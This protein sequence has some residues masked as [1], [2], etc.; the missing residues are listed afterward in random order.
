MLLQIITLLKEILA[1]LIQ[2]RAELPGL[3][4]QQ[5]PLEEELLDNSDAKRLLKICAKT[6]YRWRKKK[7]ISSRLIG[8]KLYYVKAELIKVK[9]KSLD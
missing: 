1:V 4:A 6:L 8:N 7:L 2:I 5:V 9:E 3:L